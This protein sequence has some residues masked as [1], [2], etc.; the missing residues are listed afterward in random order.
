M[1]R[2]LSAFRPEHWL[3][4]TAVVAAFV[5]GLLDP[6]LKPASS[7]HAPDNHCFLL[8]AQSLGTANV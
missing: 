4:V 5:S 1:V 8:P 7:G 6:F 2:T 3:V